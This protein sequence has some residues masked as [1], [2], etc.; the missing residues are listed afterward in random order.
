MKILETEAKK[1]I[2]EGIQ[3]MLYKIGQKWAVVQWG[4]VNRKFCPDNETSEK[5]LVSRNFSGLAIKFWLTR[6]L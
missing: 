2:S 5:G 6:P 4:L 1:E 3:K